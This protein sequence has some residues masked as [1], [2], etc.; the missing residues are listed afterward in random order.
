MRQ[1]PG[2]EIDQGAAAEIFDKR[3]VAL[4]GEGGE[5][6]RRR[7]GGKAL[8]RV[9]AGVRLQDQPGV[10]ADRGSE[11]AEMGTVGGADLA[12]PCPRARHDVGQTERPADLDQLAARD[13]RLAAV[14]QRIQRQHQGGGIVVDGERRLGPGQPDEPAR[15]MIVALAAPAG[16][17]VVFER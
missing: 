7:R 13:N 14:G 15:D 10:G 17:G 5:L 8:D 4:S 3:N 9:V 6:C 11:I 1:A 2:F 12:Q 16:L